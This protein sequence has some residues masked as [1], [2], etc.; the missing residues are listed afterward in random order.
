MKIY[1]IF[2]LILVIS[3]LIGV[4]IVKVRHVLEKSCEINELNCFNN[5]CDNFTSLQLAWTILIF[6]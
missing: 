5:A 2:M 4:L 1:Y 6:C 3:I